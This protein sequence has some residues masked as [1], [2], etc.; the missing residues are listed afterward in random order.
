MALPLCVMLICAS[1]NHV[2]AVSNFVLAACQFNDAVMGGIFI[3]QLAEA[4]LM[5]QQG[6]INPEWVRS[7][8]PP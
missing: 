5:D 7:I 3:N 4:L 6:E 2:N 8:M 1:R